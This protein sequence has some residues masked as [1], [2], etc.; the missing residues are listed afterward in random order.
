MEREIKT[1]TV[2]FGHLDEFANS[3]HM[4]GEGEEGG[5]DGSGGSDRSDDVGDDAGEVGVEM[6][7]LLR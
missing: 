6:R 3:P 2:T 4:A 1:K 5:S 7:L